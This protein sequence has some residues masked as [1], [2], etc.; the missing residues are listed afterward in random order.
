MDTCVL[1]SRT[2][3]RNFANRDIT[4]GTPTAELIFSMDSGGA[5]PREGAPP[6]LRAEG[7]AE[8]AF[9]SYSVAADVG[10]ETGENGHG[11]AH[12]PLRPQLADQFCL[13][14]NI[15]VGF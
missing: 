4:F 10:V 12:M 7:S 2:A 13:T 1:P 6:R 9:T 5:A 8:L 11:E 14:F 3:S 15:F